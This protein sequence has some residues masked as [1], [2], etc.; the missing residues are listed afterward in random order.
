MLA[1]V[2]KM[3]I[4]LEYIAEERRFVVRFFFVGRKTECK[5]YS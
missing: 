2:V 1:S 4:V 3:A 5:G